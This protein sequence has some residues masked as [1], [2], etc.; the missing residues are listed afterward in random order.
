LHFIHCTKVIKYA[1]TQLWRAEK[2]HLN[3]DA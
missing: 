3:N 1:E 2:G